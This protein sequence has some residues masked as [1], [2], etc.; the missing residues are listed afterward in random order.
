ME[1]EKPLETAAQF[2]GSVKQE[3]QTGEKVKP[4]SNTEVASGCGDHPPARLPGRAIRLGR[5]TSFKVEPVVKQEE[6]DEVHAEPASTQPTTCPDMKAKPTCAAHVS[7][8][9]WDD[10]E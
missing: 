4:S 6:S 7:R 8:V 3:C 9:A 2:D 1:S 10:E 5:S